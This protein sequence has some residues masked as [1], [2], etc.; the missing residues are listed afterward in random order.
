MA[1]DEPDHEGHLTLSDAYRG[2]LVENLLDGV[3]EPE[4]LATLGEAGVPA[5]VVLA[6]IAR[7]REAPVVGRLLAERRRLR[8]V[9]QVLALQQEL[10][11]AG[12]L[13][14]TIE[15]RSCPPREV[16]YEHYFAAN[17][18]VILTDFCAGWPALHRWS[19]GYLRERLGEVEVEA[20]ADRSRDPDY[21]RNARKHARR[22]TM[23][24]LVERVEAA[25]Q[26]NDLYLVA[27]NRAMDDTGLR[28]L[29]DDIDPPASLVDRSRDQERGTFSFWFGP[30]GTITPLHHDGTNILFSQ[31][32]G[33]KRF[34]LYPPHETRL[35]EGA[36]GYYAGVSGVDIDPP[37]DP[38]LAGV[39]AK[40]IELAP[41]ETLFL[42]V[43]WWHHVRSLDV[44]LSI[45]CLGLYHPN[46][47][48][49]YRPGGA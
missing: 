21:D 25:G 31:I 13:H 29:L 12:P 36:R 3:S 1:H 27:N 20:C 4:L 45:S 19:P 6:E 11:R 37:D 34:T 10:A 17:R 42:P 44:S 24:E 38:R 15:R 22:M 23:A 47:F 9:E 33:R 14:G 48:D 39:P 40:V 41:G 7:V 30:A 16:F 32:V 26:S 46:R 8:Q 18:P 43:G 2:W 49:A 28:A 5:T 35:L